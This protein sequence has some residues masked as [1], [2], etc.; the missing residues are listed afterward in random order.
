MVFQ[1][2]LS[3]VQQ[4]PNLYQLVGFTTVSAK[5]M[6][7]AKAVMVIGGTRGIGLRLVE[8]SVG[9]LLN[10]TDSSHE[11]LINIPSSQ[12]TRQQL[13]TQLQETRPRLES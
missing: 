10:I 1:Q 5:R 8:E 9:W 13:C 12:F 7:V 4:Q 3:Q 11:I 2:A 6:A